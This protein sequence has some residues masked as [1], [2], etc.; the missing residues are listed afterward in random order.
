MPQRHEY[1]Q[2][3]IA[4]VTCKSSGTRIGDYSLESCCVSLHPK[5]IQI[6]RI[7][8]VW[9]LEFVLAALVRIS[10]TQGAIFLALAR[11]HL[12]PKSTREGLLGYYPRGPFWWLTSHAE[13]KK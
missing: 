13:S 5:C 12:V 11:F 8:H 10:E 6:R 9:F 2:L 4:H 3:A 1:I 7:I